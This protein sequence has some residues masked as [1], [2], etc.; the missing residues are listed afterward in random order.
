MTRKL[1]DKIKDL[2]DIQAQPGNWDYDPY[3]LGLYN[4][5]ELA[6]S[7]M[8]ND[9][10]PPAFRSK[11]EN[12]WKRDLMGEGYVGAPTSIDLSEAQNIL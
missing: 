7:I 4:G 8:D 12:G 2:I 9:S 6:R 10:P 3:M 11:P 5:L 1:S